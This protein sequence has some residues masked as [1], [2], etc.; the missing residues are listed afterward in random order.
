MFYLPSIVNDIWVSTIDNCGR[1]LDWIDRLN[2]IL[3]PTDNYPR[4]VQDLVENIRSGHTLDKYQILRLYEHPD[5]S[6][7]SHIANAIKQSMYGDHIFFNTNLHVNHTNICTLACKFCA[8]RRGPK[9]NDA[10]ELSIEDILNRIF[11]YQHYIDEVHTVGGLHP[12]WGIDYYESLFKGMK[13]LFPHIHIKSLTAVEIKHIA[14]LSDISVKE[15]L[16][17]L[18]D[19]GLDSLPGGGAEILDDTIRDAICRGKESSDEYLDIHREAHNLN[20]P[21]NCTML[22]GTIESPMHRIQHLIAL[23]DLQHETGGFQCFVPYPFLPD[24]S[25]L[26]EAQLATT[27]E[28]IRMISLS[29]IVLTNIPHI[30]AY[31]MNLGIDISLLALVSGADDIDGTVSHEEIMHEAGSTANLNDDRNSLAKSIT[32]IG[33]QPIQ[34]NTIYTQFRRFQKDDDDNSGLRLPVAIN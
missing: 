34:R 31:R 1:N 32:Q 7:L 21:T 18:S 11:P 2:S 25:R 16:T 5:I 24:K 10:Y 13:Q 22:F 6:L 29:R 12:N 9:S 33:A 14:M 19:A 30:K 8:F 27:N 26:P 23:R 28:I 3:P 20:I 4:N 17:R 15:T